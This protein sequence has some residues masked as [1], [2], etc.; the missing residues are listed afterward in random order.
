MRSEN[1]TQLT[2]KQIK[3]NKQSNNLASIHNIIGH[4]NRYK[5]H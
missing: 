5:R 3:T 2:E 4:W 1:G